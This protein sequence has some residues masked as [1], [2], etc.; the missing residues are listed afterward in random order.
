MPLQRLLC[1]AL[2]ALVACSAASNDS[3]PFA[4]VPVSRSVSLSAFC[5]GMAATSGSGATA[6][7][8]GTRT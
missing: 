7:P 3:D 1:L 4:S 2:P 8:S 6:R 5:E